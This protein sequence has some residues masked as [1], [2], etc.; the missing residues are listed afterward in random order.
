MLSLALLT[1]I[2]GCEEKTSVEVVVLHHETLIETENLSMVSDL[3]QLKNTL[4]QLQDSL[5]L[6]R[7][8]SEYVRS[9]RDDYKSV[10]EQAQEAYEKLRFMS[11]S[12]CSSSRVDFTMCKQGCDHTLLCTPSMSNLFTCNDTLSFQKI[13]IDDVE[14]GD[15]VMIRNQAGDSPSFLIHTV[16]DKQQDGLI[17]RG[18]SNDEDDPFISSSVEGKLCGINYYS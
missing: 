18:Y 13:G 11:N 15:V 16:V 1:M 14:T 2:M 9:Q 5:Q 4:T 10:Y 17:T 6:E 3:N 12:P 8:Y 7:N